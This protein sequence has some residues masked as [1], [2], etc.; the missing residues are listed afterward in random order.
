[1]NPAAHVPPHRKI[2]WLVIL[3]LLIGQIMLFSATGVLGLQRHG[4]EFYF[5]SRQAICAVLGLALMI[6]VS[7]LRY[8]VFRKLA[9]PLLLAQIALV[10]ATYV[11]GI[12]HFAL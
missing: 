12:G 10:G 8:Q 3:F 11:S 2:A 1:M 4:S 7:Q 6:L 5:I 9:A